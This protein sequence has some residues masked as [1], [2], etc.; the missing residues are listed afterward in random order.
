M[1]RK[2]KKNKKLLWILPILLGLHFGLGLTSGPEEGVFSF[3]KSLGIESALAQG[4][5]TP[6]GS[7]ASTTSRDG[8][9][10]EEITCHSQQDKIPCCY[11]SEWS[12][13]CHCFENWDSCYDWL[14][15]P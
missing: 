14:Y 13:E 2:T 5:W 10:Y 15:N 11:S 9:V 7:M 8:S 4:G 6:S 12:T 1:K 3:A